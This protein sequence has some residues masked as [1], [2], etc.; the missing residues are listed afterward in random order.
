MKIIITDPLEFEG[1]NQSCNAA[2]KS[3]VRLGPATN[4][5]W[6]GRK[7]DSRNKLNFI[8]KGNNSTVNVLKMKVNSGINFSYLDSVCC[9]IATKN[10]KKRKEKSK[11]KR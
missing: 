6:K 8:L 1:S 10:K 9:P 3:Y 5:Q 11:V 7:I 4:A 2:G